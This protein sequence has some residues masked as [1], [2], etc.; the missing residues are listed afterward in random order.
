MPHYHQIPS[1]ISDTG[2]IRHVIP[3]LEDCAGKSWRLQELALLPFPSQW[4]IWP[5]ARYEVG[6]QWDSHRFL[7]FFMEGNTPFTAFNI[8]SVQDS[9]RRWGFCL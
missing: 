1:A 6:D 9:Y 8:P 2:V 5:P 4:F 3:S 7:F